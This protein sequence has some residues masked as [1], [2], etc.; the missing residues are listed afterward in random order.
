MKDSLIRKKDRYKPNVSRRIYKISW[1]RSTVYKKENEVLKWLKKNVPTKAERFEIIYELS[2]DNCITT[3]CSIAK[4]S[5]SGYYAYKKRLESGT[6]KEDREKKDFEIIKAIYLK[7]NKEYW[8]RRITMKLYSSPRRMNHKKVYRLT[9]KYDCLSIVRRKNPYRNIMKANLQHRTYKNILNRKFTTWN[10]FQ[11]LW[12]DITYLKFKWCNLYLSV[13]KDIISGE[14]LSS[15]VSGSLS[16]KI[17]WKTLSQ[18]ESYKKNNKI[19]FTGSIIHSDQWFHYTHPWFSLWIK[20]MWFIQSMSR[21][22]NCLD[23]APTESFFWHMKDEVD[24]SHCSN[25]E[26]VRKYINKYIYHYNNT[27]PQW[28][29]KKMTPVEYRNHLL[30]QMGNQTISF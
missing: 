29:K 4:V 26:E 11:K 12:T 9:K 13:V 8:Y 28:N 6:I 24:I 7:S 5:L 22:W 25:L 23:N 17:I 30:S 18:L 15:Y 27:R 20:K 1:G 21:R 16:M 2:T 14:I 19:D 3:L 10:P